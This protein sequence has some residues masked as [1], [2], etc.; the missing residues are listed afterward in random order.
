MKKL[1]VLCICLILMAA[2]SACSSQKTPAQDQKSVSQGQS[3]PSA[4]AA[5]PAT[6]QT[7]ETKILITPPSGWEKVTGSVL[8]VQYM[9]NTASFMVKKENFSGK[10]LEAVVQEAKGYFEGSFD[11]VKYI[12][13]SEKISIGGIDAQKIMFTCMV[14]KMQMK[15]EYVY[16]LEGTDVYAITFGD[17]A[18]SFDSL[19]A[20]YEQILS[21]IR[22][23]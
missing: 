10:T 15:Y 12:G 16:L 14:S 13:Q 18:S 17:L 5:S 6:A 9:K 2:L 4:Q 7:A 22:F 11:N 21:N 20:D 8:P 23:E 19:S 3:D 1:M